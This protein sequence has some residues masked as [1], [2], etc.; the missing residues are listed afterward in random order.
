MS[1]A[2]KRAITKRKEKTSR[3]NYQKD[4]K[5]I[6]DDIG[7]IASAFNHYGVF[8]RTHSLVRQDE[9]EDDTNSMNSFST[10]ATMDDNPGAGMT[11]DKYFYQPAGRRIEK[12]A[13]RI[14]MPL[15][16]PGRIFRLI[17]EQHL[18][19]WLVFRSLEDKK[20]S[21]HLNSIY[22]AGLSCLLHQSQ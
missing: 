2:V 1:I 20:I 10:T 7:P 16:S 14:A 13:F 12:L 6:T 21:I 19:N 4:C 5:Y 11:V 3:R 8:G 18:R 22:S 17:E 9:T 15:L